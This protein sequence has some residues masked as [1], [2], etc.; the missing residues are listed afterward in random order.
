MRASRSQ[1][2][3]PRTRLRLRVPLQH[4]QRRHPARRRGIWQPR[5]QAPLHRLWRH[6]L[7][8]AARRRARPVP[9]SCSSLCCGARSA[10]AHAA[11]ALLPRRSDLD[12]RRRG[13]DASK[14]VAIE[15][16]NS[17]DFVVNT[18]ATGRAA[19]RA[20]AERQHGRRGARLELVHQPHRPRATM[21]IDEIVRGPDRLDA[22]LARRLGRV[23]RQGHRRAARLPDDGSDG[24]ALSD[25]S[26]IR[27]R[28]P[29]WRPAPRSSAR[30]SITPSATTRSRSTWPS[31]IADALVIAEKA[32]IRDPLIGEAPAADAARSR[33]RAASAPRASRTARYRVLVS[34]F[35]DGQPLGNFRYYGT[36]PDDPE[37]HRAARASPRAARRA[38]VR[39]LAE[40]RRLARHQQPRHARDR[41][42]AARYVKHYMFDFGSILG[43]G[44]VYA[45]RHRAGNEYI[46]EWTPGWLTLA[47]LGLY[48]AAVDASSTI[49]TCPPSVGRF[50]AEAFDPL[51]VEAG[52][53]RTRRS[54]TCGPTMRSGR[55]RIVAQL[56]RRD[57]SRGRR[58]GALHRSAGH[59]LHDAR[60]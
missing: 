39:R 9:G 36:R 30:R 5:W 27:R 7:R 46:L 52:V 13:V 29:R 38:R 55:A 4:R 43:S 49:R 1:F 48:I 11:A 3:G 12:R 31:S 19:R 42:T 53:S 56:H 50:E 26:S 22:D 41:R 17:Y 25:R 35:A 34:R 44:T 2:Q 58:E 32:T 54:T 10:P 45:Q 16:T 14:V 15:D 59:R 6:V 47:T 40:S 60:R 21:P 24:P 28:I 8:R 18:F 37:R 51:Q 57:D 23:R 20:R 33:Q